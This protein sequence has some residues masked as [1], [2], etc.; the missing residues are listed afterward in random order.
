M[1]HLGGSGGY[2]EHGHCAQRH[3][4]VTIEASSAGAAFGPGLACGGPKK[5]RVWRIGIAVI[6]GKFPNSEYEDMKHPEVVALKARVYGVAAATLVVN[7]S[8][9]LSQPWH[10]GGQ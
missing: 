7:Q 8:N 1:L 5:R 9:V 3:R 4:N 6:G 10:F 2:R